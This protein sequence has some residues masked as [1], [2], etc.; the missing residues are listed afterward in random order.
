[1]LK[2]IEPHAHEKSQSEIEDLL[3][4]F[5][6]FFP[7]DFKLA[8]EEQRSST[9]IIAEDVHYGVY[10]GA[11]LRKKPF[12]TFHSK[13][14]ALLSILHSHKRKAW[15]V[16]FCTDLSECEGLSFQ[17]RCLLFRDF[18]EKL[19]KKLMAFGKDHKSNFLIVSIGKPDY[20]M[21]AFIKRW[22]YI[23]QM[24]PDGDD[25]PFFE[26][27]LDIRPI[28]YREEELP[29][30]SYQPDQKIKRR[31]GS[32][33]SSKKSNSLAVVSNNKI[34]I[35]SPQEILSLEAQE[36]PLAFHDQRKT[37]HE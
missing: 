24:L 3:W 10:G 27:I 32:V 11:I 6:R 12:H 30:I 28:K 18:Y 13:I 4:I 35:T 33:I 31:S 22:P 9:Y 21:T 7:Q 26:G 2:I 1:M 25:F 37:T 23:V 17:D 8:P 29:C 36:Q 14:E 15:F 34:L 20:P 19:Y 16:Q 5:K